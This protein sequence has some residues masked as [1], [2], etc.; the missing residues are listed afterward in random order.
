MCAPGRM[1]GLD[2]TYYGCPGVRTP[3]PR[4]PTPWPVPRALGWSRLFG[5]PRV[6]S[7]AD[8]CAPRR[9][10]RFHINRSSAGAPLEGR[11][12]SP[13]SQRKTI[14]GTHTPFSW[15]HLR[16]LEPLGSGGF[17]EIYRAYDPN[18]DREVALK[19]RRGNRGTAA[20]YIEEARRLA[21][22]QH[23]NVLTVFGVDR[24]E[25]RIGLWTE[26]IDGHTLESVI[27]RSGPMSA[28]EA[29][30]LGI[31]LCRALAAVHRAG[32]LHR[33]IKTTNVM[34][35]TG[36]RTVL[37]DFGTVTE[38]ADDSRGSS[39]VGT[40]LAMAPELFQGEP[41]TEQSDLYSLGVL[42]YRVTTNQ[43]P[44]SAQSLGELED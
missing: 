23:A 39:L 4:A 32:L 38:S 13:K 30:L 14:V 6:R 19:L 40:P 34:R 2:K 36:G 1:I 18:L 21:K 11:P 31:D 27:E 25:G 20:S 17:G 41:P 35:E 42:L 12:L 29:A 28:R 16:V 26:L 33:D 37:M 22:V 8:V 10:Q 9:R 44:Y 15:G 7:V 24:F 43:Y 5:T 3:R